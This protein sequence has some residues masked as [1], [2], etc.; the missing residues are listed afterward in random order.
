MNRKKSRIRDPDADLP[1]PPS[2]SPPSCDV[3]LSALGS[4]GSCSGRNPALDCFCGCLPEEVFTF[5]SSQLS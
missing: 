2:A 3:A 4:V 5:L 1:G